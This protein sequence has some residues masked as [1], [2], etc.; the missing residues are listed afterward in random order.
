MLRA[1][2]NIAG[3]PSKQWMA[4]LPFHK[5]YFRKTLLPELFRKTLLSETFWKTLLPEEEGVIP[6]ELRNTFW[7]NVFQNVSGRRVFR[8]TTF[9]FRKK[10]LPD[11]VYSFKNT[12]FSNYLILI[13]KLRYKINNIIVH[14]FVVNIIMTN[15]CNLFFTRM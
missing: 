10:A 1:P 4:I 5:G 9:F 3:A 7:K 15:I 6:E 12:M 11:F 14:K 2:S 13:N 8:K